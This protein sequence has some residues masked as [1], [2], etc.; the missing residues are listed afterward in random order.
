MVHIEVT[1]WCPIVKNQEVTEKYLELMQDPGVPS[2][3][4]S[5]KIYTKFA[6][7]GIETRSYLEI[8]PGKLQEAFIDLGK[9]MAGFSEI[10]GFCFEFAVV[11]SIEEALAAQQ[12]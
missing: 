4:K 10:E 11:S 5:F 3:V 7:P 9:F 8:E 6:R 1:N 2:S 12:D